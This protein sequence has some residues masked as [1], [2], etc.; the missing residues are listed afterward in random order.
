MAIDSKCVKCSLV[1][2]ELQANK[3]RVCDTCKRA[4][5]K[6]FERKWYLANREAVCKKAREFYALNKEMLKEKSRKYKLE[7]KDKVD[8]AN[9]K[10]RNE[11]RDKI[12]ASK[13]EYYANNINARIAKRIAN[14]IHAAVLKQYIKSSMSEYLGCDSQYFREYLESLWLPN[15]CLLYTS[16]SPRDRTRSRMP[17]S[18]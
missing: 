4:G 9:Q 7:N 18:A 14:R 15:I 11:N 3:R 10:Y 12:N 5:Q 13:R 6:A 16:P 17:S 1:R 2:Q 8:A